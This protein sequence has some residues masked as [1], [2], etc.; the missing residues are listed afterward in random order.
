[1]TITAENLKSLHTKVLLKALRRSGIDD[2]QLVRLRSDTRTLGLP[3]DPTLRSKES[4]Y[5]RSLVHAWDLGFDKYTQSEVTVAQLK[6]ELATRPH[7]PN[8][9]ESKALRKAK[10]QSNRQKGRKDR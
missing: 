5:E 8:K 4:L 6:A 2:T 7:I 1:M 10:A 9:I 3:E